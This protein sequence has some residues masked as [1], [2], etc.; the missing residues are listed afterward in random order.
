MGN[1]SM[2][3]N[4]RGRP[5]AP[6][7]PSLPLV[8]RLLLATRC[9]LPLA[10]C[11]L[12]ALPGCNRQAKS[13]P[14]AAAP[15]KVAPTVNESQL[16]TIE[17]TAEAE[18]RLGVRT[19]PVE[20]RSIAKRRTYGGEVML[21]TGA[22]IIVSAPVGGTLQAV[23]HAGAPEVGA[24][25]AR[26]EPVFLLSPLVSPDRAVLTPAERTAVAQA[27]IQFSQLQI[28]TDGLVSQAQSQVDAA[29]IAVGRAQRLLREGAGTA[30]AL[31]DAKAV[32]DLASKALDAAQRRREMINQIE[33][34]SEAGETAVIPIVSP[35]D[36]FLRAE[37]ATVGEMVPAGAPLF[38]VMDFDPIWVRVPVYAGELSLIAARDPA[39][40]SAIGQ[41]DDQP[42]TSARPV[43][44]PPT[45]DAQAASVDLYY[46]LANPNGALRPGQRL[47]V[48][49]ALHGEAKSLLVP[50]SAIVHDIY[51]GAWV[52]ERTAPH[53]YTRHRVQVPFV[54]D[55]WAVLESG[56]AEGAQV[57]VEAVAELFGTEFG[58]KH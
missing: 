31:D 48:T 27:K 52:Y 6:V 2:I 34:D 32:L 22:S 25:I 9:L 26:D 12:L 5:A 58:V 3:S 46:E 37:H 50:Y 41:D 45:A 55:D 10:C 19:A 20:L 57:V 28:D 43:Q 35:R 36:G 14:T 49:L 16:N 13:K 1:S 39:R 17:L 33:L 51:G 53:Q 56:P 24:H 54:I 7:Q 15:A 30:R 40:V 23:S 38:E 29:T 21:P 11:L 42:G 18:Q 8:H 4:R 44:A 47:D